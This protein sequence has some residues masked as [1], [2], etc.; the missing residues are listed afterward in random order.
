[1]RE[2]LWGKNSFNK[3][4]MNAKIGEFREIIIKNTAVVRLR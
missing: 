4:E 1:M 2:G 3:D